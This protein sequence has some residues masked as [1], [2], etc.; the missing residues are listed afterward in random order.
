M[1]RESVFVN[2]RTGFPSLEIR[3]E[4][5]SVKSSRNSEFW[6]KNLKFFTVDINLHFWL[7]TVNPIQTL[8][9]RGLIS[10]HMANWVE[11]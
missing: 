3:Q 6:E 7:L 5:K 8:R 10:T 11:R 9:M 1:S 4:L 2:T